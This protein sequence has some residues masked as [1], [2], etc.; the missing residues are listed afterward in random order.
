MPNDDKIWAM[1]S[2]YVFVTTNQAQEILGCKWDYINVRLRRLFQAGYLGR[3]QQNDFA[4]Y[5]YFLTEAGA[6]LAFSR[7]HMTRPWYIQRK[8]TNQIP[9]EIGITNWQM[10]FAKAFPEAEF[11]RWRTDLQHDFDGEVP[12]LFFDLKDGVG[13]VPFEY[14]RMNLI[15]EEKLRDYDREFPRTYTVVQTN[16]RALNLVASLEESLPSSKLWFT[17]E[18]MFDRDITG[19]IWWTPANF[20]TRVYSIVKQTEN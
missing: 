4:P 19:K 20:R 1:F 10:K 11:R 16:K 2:R 17:S 14:E 3:V 15:K 9:H 12:D 13:W 18:E 8:A 5:L 7:G 6:T